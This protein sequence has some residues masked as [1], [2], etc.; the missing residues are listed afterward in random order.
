M[1]AAVRGAFQGINALNPKIILTP[2]RKMT[3]V[4]DLKILRRSEMPT[5]ASVNSYKWWQRD[6]AGDRTQGSGLAT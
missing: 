4:E 6:G 5:M 1:A 2:Y 3:E